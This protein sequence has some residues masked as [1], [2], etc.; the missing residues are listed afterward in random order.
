MSKIKMVAIGAT[1]QVCLLSAAL[2]LLAGV[3]FSKAAVSLSPSSGP[4]T[5]QLLVSG[6]G[7]KP[8]ATI[9]IFFDTKEEAKAIANSSGSFSKI[10]VQAPASALPGKHWVS[11]IRRPGQSGAQAPFLVNTNW[12]QFGFNPDGKRLNPYEN[13]LSPST[14]GIIDLLWSYT[15]G[16]GVPSS[17]AV[18]NGVVYVGSLDNN[19]YALNASTGAKLWNYTTGGAVFSSPAVVNGVVHVGSDNGS[20]DKGGNVYALNASTGGLLWSL[21]TGQGTSVDSSPAVANEVVYASSTAT[22]LYALN[23]G[24]GALQWTFSTRHVFS[25]SPA[26]ADGVVYVGSVDHNV[27]ALNASTGGLL[28]SYITGDL[29]HASPAVANGVVYV[30]SYDNNL[31]ALNAS[32]GAKLWSYTTGGGLYSSPAVANGV[33][34][35]GSIDNN[36]YALNATTGALLWSYATGGGVFCSPAVA[37][38][39]VYVGSDDNYVYALNASD[40]AVLWS[41]ATGNTVRSRPAVANG[42]VYVGSYDGKVYAFGHRSARRSSVS[43]WDSSPSDPEWNA[44][45]PDFNLKFAEPIAKGGDAD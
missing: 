19:V 14:V 12:R 17:P 20:D 44:L 27:Y 11:A 26:V 18:V 2:L 40:G 43:A 37:N 29:V 21:P 31:Y 7:F 6:S 42:V 25:S 36:V 24:T 4:P 28:W 41:Y 5:S 13:V 10:A 8:H 3:C 30:G 16:S 1:K 23:A 32:T 22:P 38:G 15:T 45:R 9:D 34:Y 39:V 35:V 33:V